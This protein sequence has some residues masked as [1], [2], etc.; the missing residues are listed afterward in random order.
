MQAPWVDNPGPGEYL[1][2]KKVRSGEQYKTSNMM[3][4][5]ERLLHGQPLHNAKYPSVST[6]DNDNFNT[7]ENPIISGG[8]PG[9]P[10]ALLKFEERLREKALNPFK[11]NDASF[12]KS[13]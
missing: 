5:T 8:A 6:Y 1:K 12:E 2:S 9:N 7:I 3:S 13:E 11:T 4:K 10:T